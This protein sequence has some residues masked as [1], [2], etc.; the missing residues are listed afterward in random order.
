MFGLDINAISVGDDTRD[1]P[2]INWYWS[3]SHNFVYKTINISYPF[4]PCTNCA[5]IYQLADTTDT[6]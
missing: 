5:T 2:Q 6:I 3:D 1:L 4:G